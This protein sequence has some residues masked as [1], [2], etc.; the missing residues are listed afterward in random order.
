MDAHT[1]TR[2]VEKFKQTPS[3]DRNC[4]LVKERSGDGEIHAVRGHNKCLKCIMKHLKKTVYGHS[5]QKV[6][7]AD[8]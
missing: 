6:W 5:E 8:I 3:A 2:Q 1:F 7:N 4:S